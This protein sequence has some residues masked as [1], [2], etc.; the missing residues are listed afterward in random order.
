[1]ES[2]RISPYLY[3]FIAGPFDFYERKT[4][5]LVTMRIYA[6]KTV[7]DGLESRK[8]EMFNVTEAGMLFYKRFFGKAYAF[9]KYD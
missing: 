1:M 2:D 6:R 3:A 8:D 7:F 9:R 5:G 4:E